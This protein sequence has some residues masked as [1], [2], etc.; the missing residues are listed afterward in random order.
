[1]TGRF[2]APG[3][4]RILDDRPQTQVVP[5]SLRYDF[6]AEQRGEAMVFIAPPIKLA[7]MS[8]T[9]RATRIEMQLTAGLDRLAD[10]SARRE[11]G[12]VLMRGKRSIS[13]WKQVFRRN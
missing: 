1:M 10:A 7:A 9:E 11:P 2:W 13:E 4:M 6:W 3:D 5:V 8:R 12:T